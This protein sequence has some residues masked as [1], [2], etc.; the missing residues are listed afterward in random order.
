MEWQGQCGC[1]QQNGQGKGVVGVVEVD[2]LEPVH[3][4]QEFNKTDKYKSVPQ[5]ATFSM[6]QFLDPFVVITF[7][8]DDSIFIKIWILDCF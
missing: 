8:K 2:F 3:N 4:K 5:L 1:L 7:Y 6:I